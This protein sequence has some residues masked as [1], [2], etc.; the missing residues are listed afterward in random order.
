ME[1][2]DIALR[3]LLGGGILYRLSSILISGTALVAALALSH[4]DRTERFLAFP[5][6]GYKTKLCLLGGAALLFGYMAV[7]IGR[8]VFAP[9]I[10]ILRSVLAKIFPK[11]LP[12]SQ[13]SQFDHRLLN[14]IAGEMKTKMNF[15]PF[16][17]P[18]A[19]AKEWTS[20]VET[21]TLYYML[22][23][24]EMYQVSEF[25]A[26][27]LDLSVGTGTALLLSAA[28]AQ[29]L[30]RLW[31]ALA[32]VVFIL[33]VIPIADRWPVFYGRVISAGYLNDHFGAG[34]I[35]NKP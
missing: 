14:R 13:M 5:L 10:H 17:R 24:H 27:R 23:S 7:T 6:L 35:P 2:P 3:A 20:F 8:V 12:W 19:T 26:F 22:R 18:Q 15:E 1:T 32:G 30:W 11:W 29:G 28:F 16:Q 34:R 25:I 4:L 21:M 33:L 31:L 9:L